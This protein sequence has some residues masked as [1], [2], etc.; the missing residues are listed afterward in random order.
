MMQAT[1]WPTPAHKQSMY[2]IR[3]SR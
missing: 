2:R 1:N 3:F